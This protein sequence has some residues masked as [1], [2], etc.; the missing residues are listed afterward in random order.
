MRRATPGSEALR[1]ADGRWPNE[2]I[3][4]YR[5]PYHAHESGTK[6]FPGENFMRRFSILLALLLTALLSLPGAAQDVITT[7]I[8]GGPNNMQAVNA[9]LYTPYGLAVDGS[10]NFY[11]A[12]YNQHRV[13]KVDASATLTVVPGTGPLGHLC[14]GVAGWS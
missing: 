9:N 3:S 10:G 1:S 8:G 2:R 12:S 14:A 11:I 6:E 4:P 13:F 7:I 5:N